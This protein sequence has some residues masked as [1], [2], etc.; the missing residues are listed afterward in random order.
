MRPASG[1]VLGGTLARSAAATEHLAGYAN[2][3]HKAATV[4]LILF[5]NSHI[6]R[7]LMPA[8]LHYVLERGFGVDGGSAVT[9]A[10]NLGLEEAESEGAGDVQSMGAVDGP[11]Y[12]LEGP[13]KVAV[14]ITASGGFLAAAENQVIA[15]LEAAGGLGKGAASHD[16]GAHSGE[17]TL[18][19]LGVGIEKGVGDDHAEDGVAKEFETLVG[20]CLRGAL[21]GVG[22]VGE[23]FA[24][25]LFGKGLD[26]KPLRQVAALQ[27]R[28]D[29]GGRALQDA[30]TV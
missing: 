24:E 20:G 22:G 5:V 13:S 2:L 29:H 25:Q 14:A 27:G 21:V 12:S 6:I 16:L 4:L 30:P 11:D 3:Y 7:R 28:L 18:G 23:G 17:V 26:A 10:V 15:E 1:L 8:G 9:N 19:R